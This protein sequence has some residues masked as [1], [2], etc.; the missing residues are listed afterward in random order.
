VLTSL[1]VF[2]KIFGTKIAAGNKFVQLYNNI[3]VPITIIIAIIIGVAQYLK[4][5]KTSSS[6]V[7][8]K[9]I[10]P[11]LVSAALTAAL[12]FA[13]GVQ[14]EKEGPVFKWLIATAIAASIFT[15]VSN[16]F[17]WFDVV[18]KK[19]LN[20]GS[21]I[22][23]I[24]FAL[25]LIGILIS[26]ANQ[27]VVSKND[28]GISPLEGNLNQ[29][30]KENLNL[31]KGVPTTMSKYVVTYETDSADVES[32]NR[33]YYTVRFR[34][35]T[36]NKQFTL[37]PNA[38]LRVKGN[39]GKEGIQ[40]NPDFKQYWNSDLFL[41]ITSLTDPTKRNEPAKFVSNTLSVGDT[42]FL[43][44]GYFIFKNMAP[45]YSGK[46]DTSN[47]DLVANLEAVYPNNQRYKVSPVY[48]IKGTNAESI[49]DSIPNKGVKFRI[50]RFVSNNQLELSVKDDGKI[51]DYITIKVLV[52]PYIN[53]MWVG[54]C[55]MS[56]GFM[57]ALVKRI[58]EQSRT[59]NLS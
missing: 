34:D 23:H 5:K 49:T 54:L 43:N 40:P 39:D 58:K 1:P 30:P 13:E 37:Y 22:T 29:D 20:W 24:G 25:L 27:Q 4:Y 17:Y 50:N 7:I 45:R 8:K 6:F 14:F 51:T 48:K 42:A 2:N 16:A 33:Q 56:I 26:A 47:F 55:V 12:L 53:L 52:F 19:W 3:H 10:G 44:G 15:L 21:S 59:N 31:F 57:I 9:L 38:F 18:R 32:K 28:T 46:L 11:I 36:N 41:Y 35:T